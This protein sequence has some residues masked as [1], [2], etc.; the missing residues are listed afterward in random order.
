VY[1]VLFESTTPSS[2]SSLS[3]TFY[4]TLLPLLHQ[5]PGFIS[6]KP[7]SSPTAPLRGLELATFESEEANKK[8]RTQTTHVSIMKK[9]RE[10]TFED[11]RIRVGYMLP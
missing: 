11:Y 10:N 9:A 8:W 7:Y 4:K 5:N 1:F 3:K 6:D 2:K